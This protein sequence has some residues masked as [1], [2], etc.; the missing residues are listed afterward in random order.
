MN[1][2]FNSKFGGGTSEN[3]TALVTDLQFGQWRFDRQQRIS[4]EGRSPDPEEDYKRI[5]ASFGKVMDA[6]LCHLELDDLMA[7]GQKHNIIGK[8]ELPNL[9]K[10]KNPWLYHC[11]TPVT[12]YT[13]CMESS[14]KQ[15]TLVQAIVGHRECLKPRERMQLCVENNIDHPGMRPIGISKSQTQIPCH[16]EHRGLMR[17][18]LN[19]LWHDY[20]RAINGIGE[21]EDFLMFRTE[22]D[23]GTRSSFE[24]FA[25]SHNIGT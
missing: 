20:F 7:C 16:A 22:T 5:S 24:N 9:Q 2:E 19:H 18:G 25:K 13:S 14:E 23:N 1:K 11:D 10:N 4:I 12:R 17:C 21:S 6:Y 15:A 3:G 8:Q